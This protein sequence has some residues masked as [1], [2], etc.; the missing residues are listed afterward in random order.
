MRL[1]ILA[2]VFFLLFCFSATA[3]EV[4]KIIAKVNNL[5]ITSTDLDEYCK[6]FAYKLSGEDENSSCEDESLKKEAL[7]RLIEDKLILDKAKK[8]NMEIPQSLIDKKFNQVVSGYPSR[9]VFEQSLSERGLTITRLKEK[10]REQ[11]LMRGIIDIYVRSFVSISPQEVNRYYNE[12]KND[13]SASAEFHFYLAKSEDPKIVERI[14]EVIKEK[15][16]AAVLNEFRGVLIKVESNRQEL[17]NEFIDVLDGLEEGQ[18]RIILIDGIYHLISLESS[19]APQILPLEA[20]REQIL[21]FLEDRKFT[22][23]FNEWVDEL[24]E[25]AVIINYCE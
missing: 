5:G 22:R 14:S 11:F 9:E 4:T 15:G 18:Q 12:N 13:F 21:A 1:K 7:E 24:K 17:R 2:T 6:L 8:E 19:K 3:E 20:I 16:A 25:N 23:R 10:I